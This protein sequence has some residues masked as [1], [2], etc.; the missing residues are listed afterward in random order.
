MRRA[1][2]WGLLCV[3]ALTLACQPPLAITNVKTLDAECGCYCV[4]WET[5]QEAVCKVTYCMD[6]L[7]YTSSLEPE[8]STLHSFG[9]PVDNFCP[10]VTITAIGR[11]GQATSYT[12]P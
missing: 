1:I 10:D 12:F 5:N 7:C 11:D 4:S 9:I 3:V 2:L 8:Y 6:R